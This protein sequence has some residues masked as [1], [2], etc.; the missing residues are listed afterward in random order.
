MIKLLVDVPFGPDA[1][2]RLETISDV[3]IATLPK[4]AVHSPAVDQPVDLIRDAE[5]LV[6]TVPPK[7]HAEMRKLRFVQL[8]S[9]GYAQLYG[10]DLP[11]RGVRAANARGVYDTSIAE[12]NI[13]MIVNLARDLRGMIRN[14][15]HGI[16]EI[17]DRF[18]NEIRDSVVGLWGYG[19][20]GRE[21][22]RVC[23]ALGMVVHAYARRGITPRDDFY[24]VPGTGDLE[25]KLPDRVFTAGQELEFL[26]GLDFL[27]LSMPLTPESRGIIGRR[28]FEAMKKSAFLL[29]PAR[30]PLVDE[31][32][33]LEALRTGRI[34]GAALDTHYYY[35]MPADHPLWRFPN[36]IMTPHI[37]GSD[38]GPHFLDRFLGL[39]THNIEA[40]LAGRPL[41]NE[42]TA[43]ELNAK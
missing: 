34:A 18:P 19:G 23:K 13:A 2:R 27:V 8:T 38:R 17:R 20:I 30:G 11:A 42:L 33:L 7:N 36:V 43:E 14:Q 37:S 35:P 25:G 3:E 39:A 31:Q 12:W 1:I 9:V 5:I 32:A 10:L 40:F 15:E 22:A 41:Y 6:C 4:A 29:N 21:T 16:H 24:V 28:E 26:A